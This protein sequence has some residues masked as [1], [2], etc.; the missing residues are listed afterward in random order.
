VRDLK[1]GDKHIIPDILAIGKTW[2]QSDFA[3]AVTDVLVKSRRPSAGSPSSWSWLERQP[4]RFAK[5]RARRG[6]LTL[7]ARRSAQDPRLPTWL[8]GLSI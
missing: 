3:M 4:K 7:L 1:V 6:F 5:M 2:S 8:I